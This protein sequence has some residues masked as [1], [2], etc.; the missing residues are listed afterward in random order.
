MA[1]LFTVAF[2]NV[3][4]WRIYSNAWAIYN[5][6]GLDATLDF[7]EDKLSVLMLSERLGDGKRKRR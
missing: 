4:K 2:Q 3:N 1:K 6:Q 7:L 5:G